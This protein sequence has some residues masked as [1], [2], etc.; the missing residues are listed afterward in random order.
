MDGVGGALRQ[1][2]SVLRNKHR[3]HGARLNYIESQQN[4]VLNRIPLY[5]S[6][7]YGIALSGQR[8]HSL[9]G[10]VLQCTVVL[11]DMVQRV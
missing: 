10:I 6:L 5:C 8:F 1:V 11:H 9:D 7:L 4:I 3:G 2:L